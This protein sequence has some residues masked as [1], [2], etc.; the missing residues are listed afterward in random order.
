MGI[1]ALWIFHLHCG[2]L[3]CTRASSIVLRELDWFLK[4]DG[5]C[6]VDIFF[7]LSGFGLYYSMLKNPATKD[8]L[9]RRVV[10][11]YPAYFLMC[12]LSAFLY[13]WSIQ[14]LLGNL[15]F[16]RFWFVNIYSA[17]WFIP[18]ILTLY[19]LFPLYYRLLVGSRHPVIITLLLSVVPGVLSILLR[20]CSRPDLLAFINKIPAFLLGALLGRLS[21]QRR[22]GVNGRY[23]AAA[24]CMLIASARLHIT[25]I[26]ADSSLFPP[27]TIIPICCWR[28]RFAYRLLLHW[29][30]CIRKAR[31]PWYKYESLFPCCRFTEEWDWNS[32]AYRSP[33][34]TSSIGLPGIRQH[35]RRYRTLGNCCCALACQR[36]P[37]VCFGSAPDTCRRGC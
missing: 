24:L 20:H 18:A 16:L 26:A 25:G 17:F 13:D 9:L 35:M 4:T 29:I 32:T 27:P 2:L 3:F 11:V 34:G 37:L 12:C 5:Y 10:R 8:F 21:C 31:I 36:A 28:F 7:I 23:L 6:G 14:T 15:L 30:S 1:A 22:F 33:Y 19:L